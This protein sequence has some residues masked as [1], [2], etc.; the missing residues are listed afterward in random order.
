[1]TSARCLSFFR[2]GKDILVF[3]N[4]FFGFF[5][6]K[7][8]EHSF[9]LTAIK[10]LFLVNTADPEMFKAQCHV[11]EADSGHKQMRQTWQSRSH[12]GIQKYTGS[13]TKSLRHLSQDQ[14]HELCRHKRLKLSLK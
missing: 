9:M 1:M 8:S 6:F 11:D 4:N 10:R 3:F 7:I 14:M 5:I 13:R 2:P 12:K